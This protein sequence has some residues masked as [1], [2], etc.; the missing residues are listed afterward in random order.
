MAMCSCWQRTNSS[1]VK[2]LSIGRSTSIVLDTIF[3]FFSMRFSTTSL[4]AMTSSSRRFRPENTWCLYASMFM[5]VHVS[6]IMP[7]RRRYSM[8]AMCGFS[9]GAVTGITICTMRAYSFSAYDRSL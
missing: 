9:S 3:K 7:G 8:S 1:S 5:D 4:M 2:D 6:V